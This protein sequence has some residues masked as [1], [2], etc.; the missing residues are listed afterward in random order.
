M[1]DVGALPHFAMGHRK[2]KKKEKWDSLRSPH[3]SLPF[4]FSANVGVKGLAARYL[5]KDQ[6][7]N[8]I[9]RLPQLGRSWGNCFYFE[10]SSVTF[11]YLL[12]TVSFWKA[13]ESG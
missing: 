6:F 7:A 4:S 1:S 3:P 8:N 13:S 2:E 12:Q 5:Q 11:F 9:G 10:S